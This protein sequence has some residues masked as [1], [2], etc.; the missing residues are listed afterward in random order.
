MS[1]LVN[2][3]DAARGLLAGRDQASADIEDRHGPEEHGA[4]MRLVEDSVVQLASAL[5]A[6]VT[7]KMPEA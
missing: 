4:P 2:E 5:A 7:A 1:W 6:I 3:M